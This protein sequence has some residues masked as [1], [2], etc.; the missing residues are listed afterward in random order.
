MT[1]TVAARPVGS[2]LRIA[3]DGARALAELHESSGVHGALTPAWLDQASHERPFE[4]WAYRSPEQ[5]GR[6]Q[7]PID[8][9]SDLYAFGV[10]LYELL[11][12]TLPFAATDPLEWAHR[13]VAVPPRRPR[14]IDPEIPAAVELIV[15]RLLEKDPE[16][17]YQAAA[18]LRHDLA[19]CLEQWDR[20]EAIVPFAL[21]ERDRTDRLSI[22][23]KVHGRERERRLLLDAFA[24]VVGGAGPR[25]LTVAGGAG[26]GKSA[27]VGELAQ[28]VAAAGGFIAPGKFHDSPQGVLYGPIA[29]GFGEF[30]TLILAGGESA[31]AAWRERLQAALGDDGRL[32]TDVVPHLE[33]VLGPQPVVESLPPT[34][35][36]HRFADAF[37]R[38]ARVFATP[39]QPLVLF[40]DDLQWADD[41]SLRLLA[42]LARDRSLRSLLVVLA[43]RNDVPP[44]GAFARMLD[45]LRDADMAV[46]T[47]ELGPLGPDAVTDLL[48]EALA[49]P[50]AECEP[51]R[52][53]LYA[54]TA[55]NPLFLGH[56]LLE[57]RGAGLL[58]FDRDA[59]RWFWDVEGIG[60]HAASESASGL[61]ADRL[62]GCS[63][64]LQRLLGLAACLEGSF[65]TPLLA[66]LSEIE[67][68]AAASMLEEAVSAGLLIR[69]TTG[70]RFSHDRVREV[71]YATIPAD[72]RP[73]MHLRIGRALLASGA[74]VL[75]AVAQL[76]HGRS[77][78]RDPDE[79]RE[80][81]RLNLTAARRARGAAAF[82][83]VF[84][85]CGAGL[86]LLGGDAWAAE[87]ELAF[88]FTLQRATAALFAGDLEETERLFATAMAH[89]R[90]RLERTQCAH[91]AIDLKVSSGASGE[92]LELALNVLRSYGLE[93]SM[94][95][96]NVEE[97]E[98]AVRERLGVAWETTLLELPLGDDDE[99]GA[100]L[101]LLAHVG[102]R[103]GNAD[104]K[105]FRLLAC[106]AIDLTLEHGVFAA[107]VWGL[108]A[109][110]LELYGAGDYVEGDRFGKTAL[111]LGS[112][113]GFRAQRAGV[114]SHLATNVWT[115][116]LSAAADMARDAIRFGIEDGDVYSAAF[117][118][119]L[120][121]LDRLAAG[122][123]LVEV[124]RDAH[125]GLEVAR[126]IHLAGQ[127]GNLL[128]IGQLVRALAGR[129]ERLGA[130]TGPGLDQ[131]T[132]DELLA[133]NEPVGL[134]R[135][136][137]VYLLQAQV[138][139]GEYS[140]A[141]ATREKVDSAWMQGVILVADAELYGALAIAGAGAGAS[142]ER[143][144]Q[145]R[146]AAQRF[147]GWAQS[148]PA[149]FAAQAA[150]IAGEVA[151]AEG[152]GP[153]ALEL[154][155]V[156]I[157][158]AQTHGAI[159]IQALA[160]ESAAR[161]SREQDLQQATEAHLHAAIDCYRRWGAAAKVTQLEGG[162]LASPGR[163]P[164]ERLDALA[165]AK[166]AQAISREVDYE[167]MLERLLET[168]ITQAGARGGVLLLGAGRDAT[169]VVTAE[170]T[171]DGVVVTV[172]DPP[173]EPSAELVAETVVNYVTTTQEPLIIDDARAHPPFSADPYIVRRRVRSMLCVPMLAQGRLR[174]LLCLEN[175]LLADA[176][177]SERLAALDLITAQAVISL[178]NTQ[179]RDRLQA[180]A[181]EQTSLHRVAALVA[182]GAAPQVVFDAV[183]AETGQLIRSPV[184]N[185]AQFTA[186]GFYVA[187][188]GWSTRDVHVPAGA[189]YRFGPDTVAGAVHAAGAPARIDSYEN[190]SSE[191]GVI[192][193]G[194]AIRSAVG[195][196]IMI[197]G[198]IWGVLQA[199]TDLPDP[200]PPDTEHRL[201][202]FSDL[203]ATAI[204]NA[205]VRSALIASRARVVAAGD[206]A[207]RRI[208]R[209][210]H[211]GVQQQLIVLELH[212]QELGVLIPA[213]ASEARAALDRVSGEASSVF[214]EVRQISR[215]LHPAVLSRGGLRA[216]LRMLARTS[217]MRVKLDVAC[218][219]RLPES[220]EICVYYV[221]AEC[222][223]NA[224]KHSGAD[225]VAIDVRL[226][227]STLRASVEDHGRG[228]AT[229]E[230]GS[231]LIGLI[232]RVEAV[233]GRMTIAR[234]ACGGTRIAMEL[235]IAETEGVGRSGG[236][237]AGQS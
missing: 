122:A 2:A 152:R 25:V 193:R 168:A 234:P 78:I 218:D 38:F 106:L 197:D 96:D 224:A 92:G 34:E 42:D 209:N 41:G 212:L 217:P 73:S 133:A 149:N 221:V 75:E 141:L 64:T 50:G 7:R 31:Q 203:A 166:A 40:L 129:T 178:E 214:D 76:N 110:G 142:P 173:L 49:M 107:S 204:S 99:I 156:A 185:L 183:C 232:D 52:D 81:A 104:R 36:H 231:G 205:A 77:A 161:L 155:A 192:I 54:Q 127:A 113:H 84:E 225:T 126:R 237:D 23:R 227:G 146:A 140:A 230:S 4:M 119:V 174:G 26:V 39:E 128:L 48:A 210:L 116:D 198:R 135:W 55:G 186:D 171:N 125:D 187:L 15:L 30:I 206:E 61:L 134:P 35:A 67:T 3:L 43:Y 105:V 211:D 100:V 223:T 62:G 12:G 103:A 220:I 45:A 1:S 98:R 63:A 95:P 181:E 157:A 21:G 201:A 215:G 13:H 158:R 202:Q 189:R 194:N 44:G 138:L 59:L 80:V 196:P 172:H 88:T 53:V 130:L 176:F 213:E 91:V 17:R 79:R 199:G 82:D 8:E 191:L 14:S 85:Y 137:D 169:V 200:L 65:D 153:E 71:A 24:A 72:D 164:I 188:S 57:L 93:V 10:I 121:C 160:H 70:Y 32:L 151:R 180:M 9:R 29:A 97:A 136:F 144:E 222:L 228:G 28:P 120:L 124:E 147:D 112:R 20:G 83:A 132:L 18:G 90:T 177:T 60:R 22:S 179:A 175:D 51:L 109:Y 150:L 139:A 56:L 216:A 27:L 68:A 11:T 33:L 86:E 46:E 37:R 182:K 66:G 195:A 143:L 58:R 167:R 184:V 233:G 69:D 5:T 74:D 94:Q 102:P 170:R 236:G 118:W 47:V 111:A 114:C 162:S 154:F 108:A 207:R 190:A 165:V 87:H 148:C 208:E 235:P 115:R 145:L 229:V 16:G 117:G 101:E 19:R 6:L 131:Q 219:A 123:P 226:E 89:A 163:D 159:N